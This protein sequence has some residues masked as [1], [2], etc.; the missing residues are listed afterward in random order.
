MQLS[1]ERSIILVATTGANESRTKDEYA[2]VKV[3]SRI[4]NKD[5]HKPNDRVFKPAVNIYKKDNTTIQPGST[6]SGYNPGNYNSKSMNYKKSEAKDKF[7]KPSDLSKGRQTYNSERSRNSFR[8]QNSMD[9]D[10]DDYSTSQRGRKT[11]DSKAKNQISED[12][13]QQDKLETAKRLEREKKAVQKKARE[14]EIERK[15]KPALKQKRSAK[16]WTK[17]Y[18]NGLLDEEVWM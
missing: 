5:N 12:I 16:D 2:G 4:F 18:E 10:D 14:D 7:Y 6:S 17:D 8:Y 11:S 3:K 15:K 9:K 1:K 13:E